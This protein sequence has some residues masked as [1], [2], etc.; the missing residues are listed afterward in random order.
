MWRDMDTQGFAV[1][2]QVLKAVRAS[3]RGV[4]KHKDEIGQ[5]LRYA[6]HFQ[7]GVERVNGSLA[8][9]NDAVFHI[10]RL[11]D[12]CPAALPVN[13]LQPQAAFKYSNWKVTC[14]PSTV[15]HFRPMA[16]CWQLAAPMKI[17][18]ASGM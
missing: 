7:I 9:E 15:W 5:G 4:A 6:A 12:T 17:T 14:N 1:G 16:A 10:L 2:A 11:L 13:V 3:Q 18:C 8:E